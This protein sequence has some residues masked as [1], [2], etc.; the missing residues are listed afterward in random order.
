MPAKTAH[1][2]RLLDSGASSETNAAIGYAK[3]SADLQHLL[4]T[5]T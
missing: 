1:R 2:P 4:D 5:R 3:A